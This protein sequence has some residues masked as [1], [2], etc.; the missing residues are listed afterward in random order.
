MIAVRVFISH[1]T[2]L[3]DDLSLRRS[4]AQRDRVGDFLLRRRVVDVL[5]WGCEVLARQEQHL[6]VE[7]ANHW[8]FGRRAFSWFVSEFLFVGW[9]LLPLLLGSVHVG[10]RGGL[11]HCAFVV[12]LVAV[13]QQAA[14]GLSLFL[15]GAATDAFVFG[16]DQKL[17]RNDC[18]HKGLV[19]VVAIGSSFKGALGGGALALT[20][21]R[22]GGRVLR[23]V[24]VRVEQP[25]NNRGLELAVPGQEL[26]FKHLY[27]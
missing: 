8:D 20:D 24:V 12:V 22:Q 6:L 10:L 15:N 16:S 11:D 1:A 7:V 21:G 17:A 5:V 26:V 23:H 19:L 13:E 9:E 2:H 4:R 3:V 25:H 18:R 14:W 27:Y